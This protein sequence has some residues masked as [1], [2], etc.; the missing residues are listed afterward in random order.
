MPFSFSP[1]KTRCAGPVG[2]PML[3][4]P[5]ARQTTMELRVIGLGYE[6]VSRIA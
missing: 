4:Q 3:P 6:V 5:T 1:N 2:G